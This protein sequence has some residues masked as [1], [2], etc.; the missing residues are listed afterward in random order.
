MPDYFLEMGDP[1][2]LSPFV[3]YNSGFPKTM[4]NLSNNKYVYINNFIAIQLPDHQLNYILNY[5]NRITYFY[6]CSVFSND[7][8]P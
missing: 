4:N 8:T 7:F 2:Q 3:K 5:I 1:K 6:Y